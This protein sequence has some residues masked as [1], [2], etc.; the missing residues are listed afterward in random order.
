MKSW[1]TRREIHPTNSISS[2]LCCRQQHTWCPS[3]PWT[4]QSGRDWG[5]P[6]EHCR[7]SPWGRT[8][9]NCGWQNSSSRKVH[10]PENRLYPVWR[11]GSADW[12][13]FWSSPHFHLSIFR[14][15]PWIGWPP[16]CWIWARRPDKLEGRW[17]WLGWL[18]LGRSQQP[19]LID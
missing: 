18:V 4:W 1:C 14:I 9:C 3:S 12:V 11:S 8:R 7:R 6:W 5:S 17:K 16:W 10:G 2:P 15:C 13:P 19:D